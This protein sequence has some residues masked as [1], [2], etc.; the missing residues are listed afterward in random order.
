[1]RKHYNFRAGKAI[2]GQAFGY[3]YDDIGNLTTEQRGMT[4]MQFDYTSNL[5]NQ[6]TQRLVPGIIPVTGQASTT[7]TVSV[8]LKNHG[9]NAAAVIKPTRDGEYFKAA[10]PVNNTTANVTEAL[11]ITAVKFNTSL[12][13]DVV[14][15]IDGNYTVPQTPQLFTY[16]DDGNMTGDGVWAYTWNGE[17]RLIAAVQA[18]KTKLE[19]K[20]DYQGRRTE[21]KVYSWANNTWSVTKYLKFVYDGYKQIAEYDGTAGTMQK[22]YTWQPESVGQDVPLWVNNGTSSYYYIVDGNKNI[23]AMVDGTGAMVAEYEYGPFGEILSKSGTMADANPFRFSSEYYDSETGLVYY[24]YRYYSPEFRRWLSQDPMTERG[25]INIYILC[26]NNPINKYD[27]LGYFDLPDVDV[28]G[29]DAW[30]AIAFI[31]ANSIGNPEN[32]PVSEKLIK[33]YI[34]MLGDYKLSVSE[35]NSLHRQVLWTTSENA[36]LLELLKEKRK[37]GMKWFKYKGSIFAGALPKGSL[38]RF[39]MH[40]DWCLKWSGNMLHYEGTETWTDI[41]DFDETWDAVK[42]WYN[43]TPTK[44]GD[45]TNIARM[46]TLI[47]KWG[48]PGQKYNITSETLTKEQDIPSY[49]IFSGAEQ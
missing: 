27:Y 30:R 20:Y 25:G 43:A 8:W 3:A 39:Y 24:N 49:K 23:R 19:F 17:N 18:N 1:M 41:F 7:S 46:K 13:K 40:V 22:N 44:D 47:A 48:L 35:M 14:K 45:R 26:S 16:D 32:H 4:E 12:D 34:F 42:A 28:T 33:Q 21:M 38:G 5:V 10:I 15:I 29:I 11:E 9:E 36:Q 2:P 37:E 31:I 6:Y